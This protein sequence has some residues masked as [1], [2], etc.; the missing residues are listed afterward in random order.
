M[1]CVVCRRVLRV[2]W[3]CGKGKREVEW[4]PLKGRRKIDS[5]ENEIDAGGLLPSKNLRRASLQRS[6]LSIRVQNAKFEHVNE[7]F[8]NY[9]RR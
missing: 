2:V 9:S 5:G 8:I 7:L 4:E 3:K 1:W 6:S